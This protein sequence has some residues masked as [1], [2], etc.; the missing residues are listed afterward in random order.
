[1]KTIMKKQTLILTTTSKASLLV[2]GRLLLYI[3]NKKSRNAPSWAS[4]G[5]RRWQSR[6][7]W[8][9]LAIGQHRSWQAKRR[10]ERRRSAPSTRWR[11]PLRPSGASSLDRLGGCQESPVGG[12]SKSLS[13]SISSRR[14]YHWRMY[15][16]LALLLETELDGIG[17]D[18]I[19]WV[20][21]RT[22]YSVFFF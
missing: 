11:S 8:H 20:S 17:L 15:L 16:D 5:F 13:L 4:G 21:W 14:S 7:K 1:M 19:G 6:T 3:I 2:A 22:S 12:D 10:G 18:W 9:Y